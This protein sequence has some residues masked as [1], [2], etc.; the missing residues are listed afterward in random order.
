MARDKDGF[1]WVGTETGLSRF[2]GTHFRNFY[3][4]DGLPD[5]EITKLF[6]DSRNRVWIIPF[7]QALCYYAKGRIHNR[8][9]DSLLRKLQIGSEVVSVIEDGTGNIM[10]AEAG[11]VHIIRPDGE[12]IDIKELEGKP[13]MVVQAGLNKCLG[14]RLLLH[15]GG[16]VS[17][18][19]V[20]GM[21][22]GGMERFTHQPN[23]YTSTYISPQLGIYEDGDS[24]VISA[25][26][27]HA[28]FHLPVPPGFISVSIVNDS[29]ITI[30]TYKAAYL[31]NIHRKKVVDSFLTG[32][33]VNMVIEDQEGSLWFGTLGAG[34]Y[35]L[36]NTGVLNYT[37]KI[38]NT[39]Y[40]VYSI[41]RVGSSLYAGT[42][43]FL[44]WAFDHSRQARRHAQIYD[45]FS[46]GRII[47]IAAM[48]GNKI[49]IGTDAGTFQ[50][51][52]FG[53]KAEL[54][55]QWG[56]VKSLSVIG[57]TDVLN[58]S[59]F[60][61]RIMRRDGTT[62][63]II[64]KMRSTCGCLENG[65]YYI[66]TLTGVFAVDRN[67]KT[68]WLGERYQVLR[69]RIMAIRAAPDGTVWVATDGEGLAAF[70][71]GRL[72]CQ[73]TT[74]NGLT[75]NM[76]R[77]VFIAG[78]DVWVGTDKGLNRVKVTDSGYTIDRFTTADG[79]SSDIINT[80]YVE[81]NDVYA[82]T[83]EGVN[84]FD[85][86]RIS[87]RSVCNLQITGIDIAGREWPVDTTGFVLSHGDNDIQ[88]DFVG[89]SYISGGHITYQ[90]R[91]IGLDD[92]WKTTEGT[93]L[94]YPS[95]PSGRYELQVFA[96]N[97]FGIRSQTAHLSFTIDRLLWERFWFRAMLALAAL[98]MIWLLFRYR[99]KTIRKKEAEKSAIAAKIAEL[100]Q[101]ALISRMNPHFIFNCLN[102]IQGYVMD[103][104]IRAANE[105]IGNFSRLIRQTL[106]ISSHPLL[107]LQAEINY[108]S[109]YMELEKRRFG[110]KFVYRI[111]V[112]E[113]VDKQG[114]YL[115]PMILQPFVENAILHGVGNRQD[116]KGCVEVRMDCDQG[117]LLCVIE[118]N[119]VGRKQADQYKTIHGI[120][121]K[122]LGMS[123]TAKRI[124]MLN[125]TGSYP[126]SVSVEDMQDEDRRPA[127]TR[128]T[129]NFPLQGLTG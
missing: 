46:R 83:S 23:G 124:H 35:R 122:P 121:Y 112:A 53:K 100:E 65:I 73:V 27:S 59:S 84:W 85:E 128:V 67:K 22:L 80:L 101:M 14:F 88:F 82:G 78:R 69:A 20:D 57:D 129:I 86:S 114:C 36:S 93:S 97:H 110:N 106:D 42:D 2:D 61:A 19:D 126:V 15:A 25:A 71:S 63:A 66:G 98:A 28:N 10:I 111:Q 30:N 11:S 68:T 16:N 118:D 76:C 123:L 6:V 102:S 89:I 8:D 45:R 51:T 62:A 38:R 48:A 60:D 105:F 91:L 115:P 31:F 41:Q 104:D 107:S 29:S 96:I 37:F 47:A 81:G 49:M 21:K 117:N 33:T 108:I 26:D 50:W 43:Q 3:T 1:I 40:P 32:K 127:G 18:V 44:L 4:D 72:V 87:R 54:L 58:C 7:K 120:P 17:M 90:Y 77:A 12:V 113:G 94:H 39:V 56:A 13:I 64:W 70:K 52:G 116:D 34:I 99:V 125:A 103:K 119:G 24:I 55:W 9:N 109:T 5:N 95:L 74:G 79:L 75:S 92:N